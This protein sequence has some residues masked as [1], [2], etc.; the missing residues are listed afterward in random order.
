MWGVDRTYCMPS[1]CRTACGS[2]GPLTG[3]SCSKC[4]TSCSLKVAAVVVVVEVVEE[5]EGEEVP[6][7]MIQR[8]LEAEALA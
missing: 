1:T 8:T 2:S 6:D 3:T 5:G 4:C 7:G